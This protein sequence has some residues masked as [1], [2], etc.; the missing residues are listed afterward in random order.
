MSLLWKEV[1]VMLQLVFKHFCRFLLPSRRIPAGDRVPSPATADTR[2]W[3]VTPRAPELGRTRPLP[4]VAPAKLKL[5]LRR[6]GTQGCWASENKPLPALGNT[7]PESSCSPDPVLQDNKILRLSTGSGKNT[8]L[9]IPS[10]Q[11][12]NRR[13]SLRITAMTLQTLQ[14]LKETGSKPTTHLPGVEGFSC[15]VRSHSNPVGLSEAPVRIA[16]HSHSFTW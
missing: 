8:E 1:L 11:P 6:P 13:P 2:M 10:S 9:P 7:R 15:P 5:Q 16:A 4:A 14:P 3:F 12:R